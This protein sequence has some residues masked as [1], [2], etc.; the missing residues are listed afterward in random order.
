MSILPPPFSSPI[1][2]YWVPGRPSSR[3]P[4]PPL[5]SPLPHL[6][7]R[8]R[9]WKPPGT[10]AK[11]FVG[12]VSSSERFAPNACGDFSFPSIPLAGS[13]PVRFPRIA[14]TPRMYEQFL[15][16]FRLLFPSTPMTSRLILILPPGK[17][18]PCS[19][20]WDFFLPFRHIFLFCVR[21]KVQVAPP[22]WL[23][24]PIGWFFLKIFFLA[25]V[26]L[27]VSSL[28]GPFLR[29]VNSL[30][31]YPLVSHRS[32]LHFSPCFPLFPIRPLSLNPSLAPP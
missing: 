27:V 23:P 14:L 4:F 29:L 12:A 18:D 7:N 22:F 6:G 2:I 20:L 24:L 21:K 28:R 10:W 3:F 5:P 25:A 31:P 16:L 1:R 30:F 9:L 13:I 32:L 17:V 15:S 26:W 8:F 11:R 19:S